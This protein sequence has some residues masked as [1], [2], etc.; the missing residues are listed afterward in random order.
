MIT[1]KKLVVSICVLLLFCF[2]LPACIAIKPSDVL[3]FT[4]IALILFKLKE[5]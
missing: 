3:C 5:G 4:A 2:V 1:N